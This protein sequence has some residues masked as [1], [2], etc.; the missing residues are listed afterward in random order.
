MEMCPRI[1]KF[2][3]N[4]G[5]TQR[6]T[7]TKVSQESVGPAHQYED[8]RNQNA[9]STGHFISQK[10]KSRATQVDLGQAGYEDF[11]W[12]RPESEMQ[13]AGAREMTNCATYGPHR[14]ALTK[15]GVY[16]DG[17]ASVGN[18]V[19]GLTEPN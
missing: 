9:R 12:M 14:L 7:D 18:S 10:L 4:T 17:N 19:R 2:A 5:C 3:L 6:K 11:H 15:I 13:M 8:L 16:L 1:N